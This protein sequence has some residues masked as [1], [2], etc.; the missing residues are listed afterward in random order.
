MMFSIVIPVYKAERTLPRCLDSLLAQTFGD[1]EAL[2]I[3]DGSP[4]GSAKICAQYAAADSRFHLIQQENRGVS[5][6]RNLGLKLSQGTFIAFLDSDDAYR[7]DYLES[8]HQLIESEPNLDCYWC[9]FEE[10]A[11]TK[12]PV[13]HIFEPNTVSHLCR[14]EIL[15]AHERWMDSTLWNKVFRRSIITTAGITMD[16]KLSL[17]ED[18]MFVYQ[19]LDAAKDGIA[20]I[21]LPLYLY[22]HLSNGT[23]DSKFRP[24]LKNIYDLLDKRV[25]EYLNKWNVPDKHMGKYYSS[26]F[27]TQEKILRNTFRAENPLP[28]REKHRINRQILRSE[29]FRSAMNQADCFI[30]PLYRLAY[31]SGSYRI[32]QLMDHLVAMKKRGK[33]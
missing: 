33:V 29:K 32:V 19:Y 2:M 24:D 20:M 7:S 12:D 11:D 4:D 15:L 23:L 3:D 13:L 18:M 5:A 8:F 6:A 10:I 1:F 31:R 28:H 9:G 16:Q 30:H 26:V 17:G 25:L 22:T 21:N 14:Q 27:Y